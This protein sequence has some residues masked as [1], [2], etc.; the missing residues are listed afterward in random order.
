[1]SALAEALVAAQAKA[2][3]ALE[4]SYVR[5]ELTT[6]QFT[7]RMAV[8]GCTDNI[9]QG[10]LIEALDVLREFGQTEPTYTEKR[11]TEKPTSAQVSYIGRLCAE[12]ELTAPDLAGVT[13]AQA[14]EIIDSLQRGTYDEAKWA[15]PFS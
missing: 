15:L 2:L 12:R 11:Q 4:K 7:M 9:D 1:V 5:G 14:S 10:L 6:E 13:R 3:A 8:I